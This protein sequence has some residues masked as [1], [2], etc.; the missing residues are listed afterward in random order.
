[1][2]TMQE[3]SVNMCAKVTWRYIFNCISL[4]DIS[5]YLEGAR[6]VLTMQEYS[7]LHLSRSSREGSVVWA[8]LISKT[9]K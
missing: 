1:M 2:L 3:Y 6:D 5:N 9:T 8:A 4:F 7:V